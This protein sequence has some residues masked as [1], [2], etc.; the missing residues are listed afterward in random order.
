MSFT[1]KKDIKLS[2][3]IATHNEEKNIAV[4]LEAVKGIADEIV[5]V[6]GKST[7]R[8][9]EIAKEY[10]AK[11]HVVPNNPMF[12][13]NKQKSFE[14]CQGEWILYLDADEIVTKKLAEEVREVVEGGHQE[15]NLTANRLFSIHAQN[16]AARDKV[17]YTQSLPI[18]G[19]FIARKNY[20]LG[21][22]LM[23]SGVYPDGVIRLFK[24]GRGY[25]PAKS[26]HE[27]VVIEGGVSWLGEPLIHMSDPT[28]SRYV[29]RANRYTT[30][31]ALELKKQRVGRSIFTG[32]NYIV[33]KPCLVFL[34]LFIRH[35]GFLDGFSGLIWALMSGLHWSIAYLKY[36][37]GTSSL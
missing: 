25:L 34:R 22:Y 26:V 7:D 21:S 3:A 4:C 30:L 23:H 11:V 29:E 17:T 18:N 13:I 24:R 8:T 14:L 33:I 28:F 36:L 27:Q 32:I 1:M 19:Y 5:I 2:V 31:T 6:D 12:H 15:I 37:S 9:V 35:K 10:G 20:F 16:I